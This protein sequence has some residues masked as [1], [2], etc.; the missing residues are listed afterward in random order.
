MRLLGLL[1]LLLLLQS[2]QDN[3]KTITFT[4]S[5]PGVE[6]HSKV[7]FQKVNESNQLYDVDTLEV[8]DGAFSFEIDKT[9]NAD[10]GFLNFK[11]LNTVLIFFYDDKDVEGNLKL[12]NL[13]ESSF[14]GGKENKLFEEFK[15][16]SKKFEKRKS[17]NLEAMMVARQNMSNQDIVQ[18]Q[19]EAAIISNEEQVFKK[20]FIKDNV[21]TIIAMMMLNEMVAKKEV[22]LSEV[23]TFLENRNSKLE[24][25]VFVKSIKQG[26]KSMSPVD[27]GVIAPD[28][29]GPNQDGETISLKGSMGKVTLIDFWASW[30]RPCRVENPNLVRV[31]NKYK[32][33]GF[34]IIS[35]SLDRQDQK[36]LWLKAIETDKMDWHHI[37]NLK[38][39]NDPIAQLYGVQ[40]IPA[41]FIID[42]T[43]KVVARDVRGPALGQKIGELLGEL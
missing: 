30:C 37:S 9:K 32:E 43:G 14:K 25:N 40:S 34:S 5:I 4:G 19:T 26:M 22:N 2:C 23:E 42:E 38:F 24:E 27:I 31:H 6:N 10:V 17:D 28:F 15:T 16:E 18:L 39:R 8:V 35:V 29:S 20:E 7:Y 36:S 33:K 41:T 1:T 13:Y 12:D 11:N 21:N 3:S